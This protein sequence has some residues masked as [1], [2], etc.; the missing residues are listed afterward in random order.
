MSMCW[1][2]FSPATF[3]FIIES[4]NCAWIQIMDIKSSA[5][6]TQVQKCSLEEESCLYLRQKYSTLLMKG[7]LSRYPSK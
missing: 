1:R 4:H 6:T 5:K 3:F 7:Y 2:L